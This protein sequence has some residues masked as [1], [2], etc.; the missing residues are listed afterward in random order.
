MGFIS[1]VCNIDRNDNGDNFSVSAEFHVTD[2]SVQVTDK[3]CDLTKESNSPK[4]S[5]S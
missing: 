2:I 4:I 5:E 1:C 3:D